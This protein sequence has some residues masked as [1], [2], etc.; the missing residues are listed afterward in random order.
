MKKVSAVLA[1]C[2]CLLV[3]QSVNADWDVWLKL[4]MEG[5]GE[6][7]GESVV[8]TL[9][10]EDLIRVFRFFYEVK[11]PRNEATGAISAK[12]QHVPVR[13]TKRVDK[14]SPLLFKMLCKE[15]RVEIAEFKFYRKGKD[16]NE[17]NYQTIK[18][19]GG[20]I[21]SFKQWPLKKGM[22][23]EVKF[24]FDKITITYEDSGDKHSDNFVVR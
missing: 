10:R 17:E 12:R 22:L 7:K 20:T 6:I 1:T 15:E 21:I 19:E 3:S 2:L 13:I 24:R 14:S 16:G 5:E 8:N 4:K 18:L 11:Q 9:D 23:E